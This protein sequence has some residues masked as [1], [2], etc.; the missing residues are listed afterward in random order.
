MNWQKRA[1]LGVAVFGIAC[2]V[3]VYAV[4]GERVQQVAAPPPQR[5][6]PKA[7]IESQ[8][9][10]LQQVR[11][12]RQDYIIEAAQQLTYEGGATK[13]VGVKVTINNR[14]GRNYTITA[15]EARAGEQQQELH[16]EGE[17]KLVASDGFE[18]ATDEAFFTESEGRVRAP[19]AFTFQRGRM[20][21][22][23][24]GMDYDETNDILSIAG[25]ADVLLTDE[26]DNTITEFT[27]GSGVFTRAEHLL[28]LT[29]D[30]HA[31][32]NEQV[33]D[34]AQ[35]VA[36][37]T[38]DD[39]RISA[40]ELRER[41]S[42]VGG[43]VGRGGGVG[44]SSAVGSAVG[45][46]KG[47]DTM[48][49]D[50]IDLAYAEDGQT[51]ERVA[52]RG[53]GIVG[54]SASETTAGRQIAGETLDILLAADGAITNLTGRDGVRLDLGGTAA[55]P[56]RSV[57]AK[58]LD[59]NGE[60]GKGLTAVRFRDDVEYREE[61][62]K[63]RAARLV[64]SRVLQVAMANDAIDSAVFTGAVRFDE[65][66]LQ[67]SGGE[68]LY[69][70]GKGTLKLIGGAENATPRVADEQVTV[71]GTTITIEL[72][73]RTMTADGTVKT[74]LRPRPA[75]PRAGGASGGRAAG[76]TGGTVGAT[77]AP[78]P[79]AV[80]K[81]PGLLKQEQ[82]ANVNANAFV[83]EG[84]A[85]KAVYSGAATLFQG[86]TAVQADQISIDQTRGDLT[87]TGN[88][89]S[90]I[91]LDSG[92]S[93][94]RA[95]TIT[96]TDADRL[97][98][99]DGIPEVLAPVPP[100]RGRAGAVAPLVTPAPAP[101]TGVRGAEPGSLGPAP[102]PAVPAPRAA[103]LAQ[104]SGPQGDLR[105]VKIEIVL[106]A[107]GTSAGTS[108][109]ASAGAGA[110]KV[111]RLEAYTS[112][113]LAVDKRKATGGRLTYFAADDRYVLTGAGAVPVK[114]VENCR[115]TT[116]QTLTFFKAV[117]RI[118]VDGNE[119]IRTQTTGGGPC[120]PTPLTR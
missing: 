4:M 90:T 92:S 81:L 91:V 43:G 115:Q 79:A 62:R 41:A 3:G 95:T 75:A 49:A 61:A 63:G 28:S 99:Y 119:Q 117:D 101:A 96:Y 86:D 65:Q 37:L 33:I 9:N 51:I 105:A 73:G 29:G 71:E 70:P 13:L 10:I 76:G 45:S 14:G 21:G 72:V 110:S 56:A 46:G 17:V 42:V 24:V 112:V 88:A 53:G 25:M 23:G 77:P 16:L 30:V 97:I 31:L 15:R 78:A 74:T 36:H 113:D 109:A 35:A 34:A 60:S 7:V 100:A 66:G 68:A 120:S 98:T 52:L 82:P 47:L 8:G 107:A 40:I 19:G 83:Y 1:R 5:L 2:A 18:I 114:V 11:G 111:E 80:T 20:L 87:A 6:D 89:R 69:E 32:H 58:S 50:E 39:S 67:A 64:L 27:A 108:T 103:V 57:K 118:I 116:G 26:G 84:A 38:D 44:V 85:G 59:G 93:V 48:G 104:L 94:G 22:S 55:A 12:T 54:V 106:A 102:G